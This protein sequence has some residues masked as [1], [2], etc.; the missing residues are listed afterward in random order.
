MHYKLQV[1][2]LTGNFGVG[3][4]AP[5][6]TPISTPS[7]GDVFLIAI[8]ITVAVIVLIGAVLVYRRFRKNANK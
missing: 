7:N 2:Y 6:S 1:D 5:T 4:G 3:S 8:S